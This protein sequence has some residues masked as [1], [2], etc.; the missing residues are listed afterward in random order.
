M[1]YE[2]KHQDPV[3]AF[4]DSYFLLATNNINPLLTKDER[5]LS[6]CDMQDRE[7]SEC[8]MQYREAIECRM[9]KHQ[10]FVKY[11]NND[12][13]PFTTQE[14]APALHYLDRDMTEYDNSAKQANDIS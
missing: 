6:E 13:V 10:F 12:K 4:E 1:I 8:D 9:E 3:I 11:S 2:M 14:L 5:S 7:V